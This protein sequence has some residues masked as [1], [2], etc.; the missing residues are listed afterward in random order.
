MFTHLYQHDCFTEDAVRF[1]IGEI[2]LALERLHDVRMNIIISCARAINNEISLGG[3]SNSRT[4]WTEI[5]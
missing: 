2:I 1:Y 3:K 4:S 5:S